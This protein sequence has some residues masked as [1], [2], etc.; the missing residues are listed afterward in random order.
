MLKILPILNTHGAEKKRKG[1]I[2][3]WTEEMDISLLESIVEQEVSDPDDVV[4]FSSEAIGNEQ[5]AEANRG[6]W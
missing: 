2:T 1:A 4:D 3:Q 6:R 5:S